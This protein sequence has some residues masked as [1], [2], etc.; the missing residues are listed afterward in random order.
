LAAAISKPL[1]V[2]MWEDYSCFAYE[3]WIERLPRSAVIR[4]VN[5]TYTWMWGI[6]NGADR[7]IVPSRVFAERLNKLGIQNSK[8]RIIPIGIDSSPISNYLEER[9]DLKVEPPVVFYIGGLQP[10]HDLRTLI[11]SIK[12]VKSRFTF[13]IAGAREQRFEKQASDYSSGKVKVIFVGKLKPEEVSYYL[14]IADICVAPYKFHYH[15][16]FFPGKVV[17]YMLAGKAI[18]AT[19][20]PEIREIF[21][22]KE[23]GI[24]V[25]QGDS[26]AWA[27]AL[28]TLLEHN[29]RRITIGETGKEIARNNYQIQNHTNRL[30]KVFRELV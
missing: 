23:V 20:L 6:V 16:G 12:Y 19:D 21:N 14:S 27:R 29:Q 8:I 1:V 9:F 10:W 25:P 15:S 22:N 17:R 7:V 11:N 2:E 28:D 30:M 5:R 24:L 18:I 26:K 4:D 3:S 13:I